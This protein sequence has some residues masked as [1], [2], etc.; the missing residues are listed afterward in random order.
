DGVSPATRAAVAQ[1]FQKAIAAAQDGERSLPEREAAIALLPYAEVA[2]TSDPLTGFLTPQTPQSLQAAAVRALSLQ[3]N[4]QLSRH[5]LENW[6]AFGPA[7]R[8]EVIDALMR[9]VPRLMALFDAVA[10]K[11]IKLGEI[12]RDKKQLLLNHPNDRVRNRARELLA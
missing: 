7:T 5:L 8:R 6:R 12:E 1:L 10:N 2:A 4:P 3:E 9:S 11:E